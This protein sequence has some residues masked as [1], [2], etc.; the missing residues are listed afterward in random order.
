MRSISKYCLLLF[1]LVLSCFTQV[2][3][4]DQEE[5]QE[6]TFNATELFSP[7]FMEDK[8]NSFHSASG[9]P[10]PD[11]W[12]N[13]ADYD[14]SVELDTTRK[15]VSGNVTISY[16]NNS[17][18][19]LDFLWLQL[20]QNT[21]QKD[22][23]GTAVSPVGG[24]RNTVDS[25]T[26]GY[27]I[28][29]VS[30]KMDKKMR[31][32]DYL[33][34]DT[35]MQI[36]L[37][38]SLHPYGHDMKISI[39]YSFEIP[40]YGKDRMGRMKS[41]NGRI[42]TLA[43]WYPRMSVFDE[44][45]GWNTMPYQ[46]AGEFYLEYGDFDYNI[47]VPSNMI[48]VGSGELENPKEVLTD[49]EHQ[50]LKQAS[51]S[52]KT[53]MIRTQEDVESGDR[54]FS[55]DKL[56]WEFT[57]N[58]SRDISWA[59]SQAFMWDAAR[60]NLPSGKTARAQSVYPVESKGQGAWGRSTEYVKGAIEIYSELLT[61]YSYPV[62]T[63]V[64]GNERGMEYPGIV[65]C[66]YQSSGGGLWN[67]TNH[68]FG[69]HWFPMIVGS[70]ERRYAW[71]DEGFNTYINDLATKRFNDGEYYNE[72]SPRQMAG[73]LFSDD[74][75]PIFTLPDVLVYD[76][77]GVNAY[78]KPGMALDQLRNQVLGKERF[79]YAFKEY[80]K[81][82][83]YKHP[84]PWD[85]FNTMSD[86][87]GE[88]LGWFWKG[89][90][91]N[92]YE[93]DQAIKEIEYIDGN[94]ENG[95]HITI[96]NMKKM[97]MPVTISV[98]E[99]DGD[100]GTK[101][102]PVEIWQNGA[103]W[104][105]KYASD[106]T[107]QSAILDPNRNLPDVNA[108]N[109]EWKNITPAPEGV[110]AQTVFDDYLQ[111]IGGEQKLSQ[112]EDM[113]QK[114]S[115]SVQGYSLSITQRN[116]RPDMYSREVE[117]ASMGRV[118]S[119]VLVNG[120]SVSITNSGQQAPLTDKQKTAIKKQAVLF[121]ELNYDQEGYTTELLGIES[122]SGSDAYKVDITTPAGIDIT[123]Y[124]AVESGLKIREETTFG[125]RSTQSGYSNYKD[126]D[127]YILPHLISSDQGAMSMEMKVEEITINTGISDSQFN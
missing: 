21:F 18:Y 108:E 40:Q 98:T 33:I 38:E 55:K 9:K 121:P 3:A 31:K 7:L 22:S 47:T 96:K 106:D 77:Y 101:E 112:I 116:K 115:G 16:E 4:Q 24:G 90:I 39:D 109:N 30:I 36:R 20:D 83:S 102:L 64:A 113:T 12:Q 42:Y 97:A 19:N 46:G 89:W 56:T 70:N 26:E 123:A 94:P 79:D 14:I 124:Y 76:S 60:I 107:I 41:Q 8:V 44:V 127:G 49:Q 67:V 68:E 62:A 105:F 65:F 25:Y 110:T 72:Q 86:A 11:Y 93:L 73:Y 117:V 81:R 120:D 122:I 51:K 118:V 104:T 75:Q 13:T 6:S 59:A 53:V 52:D 114:M 15:T 92:N 85:F 45:E 32:A 80:I 17:P 58:D 78:V 111:A 61:E 103:E 54:G 69:H 5:Q 27:N 88:E 126:V 74:L 2:Q 100:T 82:W 34:T 71:M 66:N 48:V 87:S 1:V 43:Q 57:M 23:R 50:R 37:P 10:G 35:R 119:R 99:Q 29:S 125:E 91:M 28:E 95:A 84:Q 63:N